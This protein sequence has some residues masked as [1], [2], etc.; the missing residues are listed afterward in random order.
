ML[1]EW[2]EN[3]K[4]DPKLPSIALSETL[5]QNSL[6]NVNY[7][8]IFFK[9]FKVHGINF[10]YDLF[11]SN[12]ILHKWT[13]FQQ[14]YKVP[15]SCFMK[16]YQL[17]HAIPNDW[18]NMIKN[19][20]GLCFQNVYLKPHFTLGC[21]MLSLSKLDAKTL[22]SVEVNKKFR[23]P[24]SQSSLKSYLSSSD[25]DWPSIYLLAR[26]VTLDTYTRVFH[27]KIVNNI[28]YL[29]QQLFK[30]NLVSTDK[31]SYCHFASENVRH[32]F[33]K[34]IVT[35]RLWFQIQNFFSSI[36]HIPNLSVECAFVG[37]LNLQNDNH[38]FL[39]HLLLIFKLFVYSKRNSKILN[40]QSFIQ[41]VRSTE[42]LERFSIGESKHKA[43]FHH[44]KWN[45]VLKLLQ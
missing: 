24:T 16:W 29:N 19:D 39:N 11:N 12:G 22:Y 15:D 25:I 33:C 1:K 41:E 26:N 7:K 35:K 9:D 4:N 43:N 3:A 5:W 45:Q 30:I 13:E 17:C 27:Y 40:I 18:K 34:C 14:L 10:V 20:N 23:A 42:N 36:I 31:C 32:L 44:K 2:T 38:V 28:L 6:I 8:Q 37:F 21:R